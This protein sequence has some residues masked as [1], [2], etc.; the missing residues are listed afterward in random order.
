MTPSE[1]LW[2]SWMEF[3]LT[4]TGRVYEINTIA[5]GEVSHVAHPGVPPIVTLDG[6]VVRQ[7]TLRYTKEIK[8]GKRSDH[9]S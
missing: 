4:S 9:T 8:N 2:Q 7:L 3:V 1:Y 6:E 5:L